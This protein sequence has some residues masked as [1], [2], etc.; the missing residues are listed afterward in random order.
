MLIHPSIPIHLRVSC[1]FVLRTPQRPKAPL[2]VST[3]RSPMARSARPLDAPPFDG[4]LS[5]RAAVSLPC[6]CLAPTNIPTG[7]GTVESS[8]PYAPSLV[9]IVDWTP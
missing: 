3:Q 9:V 7:L 1:R 6:L 8:S 2:N 4:K 5:A